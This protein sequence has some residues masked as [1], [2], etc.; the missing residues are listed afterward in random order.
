MSGSS[1]YLKFG[2]LPRAWAAPNSSAGQSWP[3]HRLEKGHEMGAPAIKH[4]RLVRLVLSL[5]SCFV[6]ADLAQPPRGTRRG[7]QF[8]EKRASLT[9][10]ARLDTDLA[11]SNL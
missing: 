7:S 3:N 10:I 6:P 9:V 4:A 2:R 1:F 8:A 11:K 5:A